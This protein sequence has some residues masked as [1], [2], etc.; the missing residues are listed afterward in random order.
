MHDN[1]PDVS[2]LPP[3]GFEPARL[4]Y[5]VELKFSQPTPVTAYPVVILFL[6]GG[7]HHPARTGRSGAGVAHSRCC[8]DQGS[9]GITRGHKIK[10]L[11]QSLDYG[12]RR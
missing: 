8:L 10:V 12:E 3:A 11:L 9:P 6:R 7:P 4:S 5:V 1:I 2:R